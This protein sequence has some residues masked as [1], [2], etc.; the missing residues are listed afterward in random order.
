MRKRLLTVAMLLALVIG[1]NACGKTEENPKPS[2]NEFF[3]KA[4]ADENTSDNVSEADETVGDASTVAQL[5]SGEAIVY[6]E[7]QGPFDIS[8]KDPSNILVTMYLKLFDPEGNEAV[9][10]IIYDE[11]E[12]PIGLITAVPGGQEYS[13]CFIV[14]YSGTQ[15]SSSGGYSECIDS[16]NNKVANCYYI[17]KDET[18]ISAL[19]DS[20]KYILIT[21]PECEFSGKRISTEGIV[22]TDV[23]EN[24][25]DVSQDEQGASEGSSDV[26]A[27]YV[28]E[29]T[30]DLGN[31]FTVAD[32]GLGY[33]IHD[34]KLYSAD[35]WPEDI[36]KEGVRFYDTPTISSVTQ[37]E[38]FVLVETIS[39]YIASVGA[40]KFLSDGT[41]EVSYGEGVITTPFNGTFSK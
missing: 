36:D 14:L 5:P 41:V 38:D 27:N 10:A 3:E 21:E 26:L 20:A 34:L 35:G 23:V 1:A 30:D 11:S 37:G 40:F 2:S 15:I 12:K 13:S 9:Q 25:E 39:Q 4:K 28:G 33:A 29:Y 18:V 6:P 19:T 22:I 17:D 7:G 8:L 31:S 24:S 16:D 32:G